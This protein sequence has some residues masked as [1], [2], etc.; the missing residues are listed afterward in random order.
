MWTNISHVIPFEKTN[1]IM[2]N[3][4]FEKNKITTY[5]CSF[6]KEKQNK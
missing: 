1:F 3:Y 5:F 6:L 2:K 4:F